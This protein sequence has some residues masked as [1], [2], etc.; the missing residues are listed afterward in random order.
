MLKEAI[1]KGDYAMIKLIW[2]YIEGMPRQSIE[3]GNLDGKPLEINNTIIKEAEEFI[4]NR[5]NNLWLL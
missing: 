3:L 1:E 5:K 2:N 4:K